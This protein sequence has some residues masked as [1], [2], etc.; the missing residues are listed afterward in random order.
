M[1]KAAFIMYVEAQAPMTT[2]KLHPQDWEH[3]ANDVW[4]QD[5]KNC[6]AR[7]SLWP[8]ALQRK[9]SSGKGTWELGQVCVPLKIQYK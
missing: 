3:S 8:E 5:R 9:M 7:G 1:T 4:D 2:L 6:G